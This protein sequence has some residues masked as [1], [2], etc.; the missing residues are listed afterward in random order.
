VETPAILLPLHNLFTD[1]PVVLNLQ[2][3]IFFQ[4]NSSPY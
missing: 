3:F 1:I 4:L 2:A